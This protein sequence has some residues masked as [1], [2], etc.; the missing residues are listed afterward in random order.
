MSDPNIK[1]VGR[2]SDYSPEHL[3]AAKEAIEA[4]ATNK[5][6]AQYL[7]IHECTFYAWKK[8]YPEFDKATT[9]AKKIANQRVE[10]RAFELAVGTTIKKQVVV[11]TRD[12]AG[13]EK[14]E[15]VDLIEEIPPNER[16]ISFWL[17]NRD[18]KRWRDKVDVDVV[19][20]VRFT[21]IYEPTPDWAKEE[22]Q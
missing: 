1:R 18:P 10:A 12:A 4:G 3:E 20:D 5:E 11:K 15:V 22:N 19:G 16:S 2:Y 7:G 17:R 6:T 13:N 14:S 8:R 21:T 9:R